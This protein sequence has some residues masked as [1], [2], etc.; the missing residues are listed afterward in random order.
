MRGDPP[1]EHKLSNSSFQSTPHARGSTHVHTSAAQGAPV[2]P[3]CAGIHRCVRSYYRTICSLPRMRGDPP[4]F[5]CFRIVEDAST[6]MREDPPR[7][8]RE[9]CGGDVYPACAGIHRSLLEACHRRRCLP[10]MRGDPPGALG[11]S[12]L[13]KLS[14]P[15]ARGST[16]S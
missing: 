3:A 14:T 8:T 1:E 7:I 11:A 2:Y 12:L 6:R 16:P 9:D 10:R 13:L 15:H 4:L 5:A